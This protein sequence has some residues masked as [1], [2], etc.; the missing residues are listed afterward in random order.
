MSY[1]DRLR[2]A[3][4]WVAAHPAETITVTIN[5]DDLA[6]ALWDASESCRWPADLS[7][8]ARDLARRTRGMCAV[9]EHAVWPVDVWE[10]HIDWSPD[11]NTRQPTHADCT[12]DTCTCPHREGEHRAALQATAPL[13]RPEPGAGATQPADWHSDPNPTPNG[14]QNAETEQ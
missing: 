10:D 14:P 13:P 5:R 7:G 11:R 2:E 3:A 8:W 12:T 4:T 9:C 1:N 6:A